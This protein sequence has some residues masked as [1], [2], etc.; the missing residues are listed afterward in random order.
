LRAIKQWGGKCFLEISIDNE[1][2]RKGI[3]L[4]A[5]VIPLS[6]YSFLPKSLALLIFTPAALISIFIDLVRHKNTFL[7]RWIN[8]VLGPIL[9][10]HESWDFTGSSYILSAFVLSV[11]FFNKEIAVAV[12]CFAILGDMAAALVG[13]IFGKVKIV[14]SSKTLEGS[15]A[16]FISCLLVII[17][18]PSFPIWI[19]LVGALIATI[20]EALSIPVND[21]FSVPLLS[22]LVME[23]LWIL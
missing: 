15:L 13:R 4:C 8:W 3:H 2:K 17:I 16:F 12:I 11:L 23:I 20:V 19:G 1:L 7:S 14:N 21:N 10:E 9:R 6:Y 22:G 18:I 5:L